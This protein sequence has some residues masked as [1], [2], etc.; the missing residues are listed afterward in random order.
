MSAF[1]QLL[2]FLYA[3][4]NLF[5]LVALGT[6]FA[7]LAIGRK[8]LRAARTVSIVSL[9]ACAPLFVLY[10]TATV[11]HPDLLTALLSALWAWN[12]WSAWTYI[13]RTHPARKAPDRRN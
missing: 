13:R 12:C 7:S 10:A 11:L 3:N 1:D 6:M 4:S 8:S 9:C 5:F 2:S